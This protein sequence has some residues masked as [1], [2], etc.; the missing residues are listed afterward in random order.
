MCWCFTCWAS[1]TCLHHSLG[2]CP[3]HHFMAEL[4]F[5]LKSAGWS[6]GCCQVNQW[7]INV[8]KEWTKRR[9]T[10]IKQAKRRVTDLRVMG[11]QSRGT[12]TV[13]EEF[14][15]EPK[16][17]AH[18]VTMPPGVHPGEVFQ[19]YQTGTRPWGRPR[20]RWRDYIYH[21]ALESLSVLPTSM[22]AAWPSPR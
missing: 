7:V 4:F 15:A 12:S 2:Q 13:Q 6:A 1:C 9:R 16:R 17:F 11:T 3:Y 22:W 19:A 21:L 20:T 14:R 10:Q 8:T 18:L 5:S